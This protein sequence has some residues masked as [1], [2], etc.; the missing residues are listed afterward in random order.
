MTHL[1]PSALVGCAIVLALTAPEGRGQTSG[2]SVPPRITVDRL[3]SREFRLRMSDNQPG[4]SGIDHY[5]L[6]GVTNFGFTMAAPRPCDSTVI[7]VP[8]TVKDTTKTSSFSIR[9]FDCA[10][11]SRPGIVNYFPTPAGV[12][13]PEIPTDANLV[14]SPNPAGNVIVVVLPAGMIGVNGGELTVRS[15]I[16]ALVARIDIGA[17]QAPGRVSV[18]LPDV[19]SGWFGVCVRSGSLRAFAPVFHIR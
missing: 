2:D 4:D 12:E 8:L 10:G 17:W 16:G 6:T 1:L 14:V 15:P 9:A 18:A 13:H 5:Q 11:N 7:T 3:S 19:P